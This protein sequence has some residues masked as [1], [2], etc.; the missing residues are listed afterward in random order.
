[1]MA[2][3]G[4]NPQ[5][6]GFHLNRIQQFFSWTGDGKSL[7]YQDSSD[8]QYYLQGIT[9]KKKRR[10]TNETRVAPISCVSPD[11]K[12]LVYQSTL[13]G[14]VDIRAVLIAGGSPQTVV[15]TPSADYHPFISPSGKWLYFQKDHKNI[16]RVPGP[17]LNWQKSEPQKITH[18][19]ESGLYLDDPQIS[20]DGSK[21]LYSRGK[22]TGDIWL[23]E[24]H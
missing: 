20:M 23:M 22:I 14:N 10:L 16:Y 24:F 17:A 6:L 9:T 15:A 4:A 13:S 1:M 12:W 19:P 8:S 3:D 18:F 21:L 7:I 2:S 5:P 11:G